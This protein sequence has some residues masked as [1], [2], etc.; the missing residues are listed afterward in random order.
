MQPAIKYRFFVKTLKTTSAE[1]WALRN[2]KGGYK[3]DLG[4]WRDY[5][6]KQE[7]GIEFEFLDDAKL[8]ILELGG[9]LSERKLIK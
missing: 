5:A 4:R 7:R 1:E 2:A 3:F 6:S 9:T 8:F